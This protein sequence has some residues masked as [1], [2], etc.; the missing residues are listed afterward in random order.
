MSGP[1]HIRMTAIK[2]ENVTKKF[3]SLTAIDHLT[4]EI[5]KGKVIGLIGPDGA[6]KTTLLR[7]L[8]GLLKPDEGC[9]LVSG[10]DV[11]TNPSLV[12][13]RIGYMPQHFSLYRDLTVSENLK[14]YADL[15]QVAKSEYD[16]RKKELLAFS[17]LSPF[18][19]RL[20]WNLSGGMQ[21]KLA[22]ACNLFHSPEILLFDEPTTGVDPVSRGELWQLLYRLNS[23]GATILLTTPY[24]DEAEKCNKVGLI[25]QGRL[26]TYKSPHKLIKEFQAEI[27]ELVAEIETARKALMELPGVKNMYPFGGALHLVFEPESEGQQ[28]IKQLLERKGIRIL[29]IRRIAP[30][31]E[32]VFLALVQDQITSYKSDG[33]DSAG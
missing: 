12:K 29:S 2:I 24:M 27:I 7:L 33:M 1:G 15:Y 21:K 3:E 28:K 32:D 8:V 19:K 10:I 20:A 25:Y 23:Q 6:G 13:E 4:L 16:E 31:F 9:I 5:E 30:S 22:L 14:F 18:E 11:A 17:A 26:L